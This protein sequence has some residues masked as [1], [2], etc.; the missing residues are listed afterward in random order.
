MA[1]KLSVIIPVYNRPDE[2]DELLSTL[3]AQSRKPDEV[4]VVE[5]G[6]SISAK[7]VAISYKD[8]LNILYL[9]KA[10]EG[11]GFARNHGYAHAT[12]NFLIVFDSD[13][14]VPPDYMH[15]VED[16][17][18]NHKVDAFGGPDAAHQDFTTIQKA[19]S[20][21]MTS[22]F[23]TG[24]IRGRKKHVGEY[25]PRSF[26]MGISKPTFDATKG[27]IIPFMGEDLEFSTRIIKQGFKTALIPEAFVYHKRRTDLR[28]FY[29]QL[30]YFGRARINL[31]RFHPE[32]I[33][34]IHL[35]PLAFSL[36]LLTSILLFFLLPVLGKPL[37]VLYGVYFSLITLE[38]TIV[39]RSLTV[40]L[41][42]P[43]A[44][45]LQMFGY[46]WGLVYEWV[47]KQQGINP[48]TKYIELY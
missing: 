38:S 29:Q 46:G 40:G 11:Q 24:G 35:F 42:T 20:H 36:G 23:T 37:L 8:Q 39:N 41:L 28:K 13:C 19:I 18:N 4:I 31:T 2:L 33:K 44:A 3:V 34:I 17:L 9:Q 22:L 48:N 25:H 5:D 12:G 16:F 1:L 30:R 10:N 47:R 7:E 45:L 15:I 32:Q 21:S 43:I 26:N 6:S 27:Y 14:L